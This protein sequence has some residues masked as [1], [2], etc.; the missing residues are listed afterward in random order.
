MSNSGQ[1]QPCTSGVWM[2]SEAQ[3]FLS[4]FPRKDLVRQT[5]APG[6]SGHRASAHC[7]CEQ[8]DPSIL[9]SGRAC[10]LACPSCSEWA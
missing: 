5:M 8:T 1:A 4:S 9:Q 6:A 3:V 10:G 7:S 2:F